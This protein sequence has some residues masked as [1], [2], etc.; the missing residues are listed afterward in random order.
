MLKLEYKNNSVKLPLC[1]VM[2]LSMS[3]VVGM[4]LQNGQLGPVIDFSTVGKTNTSRKWMETNN[5]EIVN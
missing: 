1:C 4:F 2:F 3:S 5:D